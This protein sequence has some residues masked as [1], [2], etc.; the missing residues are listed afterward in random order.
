MPSSKWGGSICGR[1]ACTASSAARRHASF[2][3][4]EKGG[5]GCWDMNAPGSLPAVLSG[6]SSQVA[7]SIPKEV[8]TVYA[9]NTH[10][11]HGLATISTLNSVAWARRNG[12]Q[13]RT[14][15][16]K[17][18]EP[19]VLQVIPVEQIVGVEG[20]QA[21][22]GMHDV[23]AGFLDGAHVEGVGVQKLH[24]QHAEDIFVGQTAGSHDFR[25]AAQEFAQ[26]LRSRLR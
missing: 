4:S 8:R 10:S 1:P 6:K 21:S 22:I 2:T 17:R 23:N 5:K 24:D 14:G 11:F 15:S 9:P 12:K 26:R 20:N 18:C 13:S 3:V 16:A 25:Q 19:R 7:A